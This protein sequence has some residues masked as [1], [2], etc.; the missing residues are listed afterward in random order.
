MSSMNVRSCR[1]LHYLSGTELFPVDL[2]LGVEAILQV[3]YR[4]LQTS[5]LCL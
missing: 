1:T 2:H 5:F 3:D 4:P